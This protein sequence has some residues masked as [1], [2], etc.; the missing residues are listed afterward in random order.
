MEFL[1]L[2]KERYSCRK[3]SPKPIEPEKLAK[4]L[5]AGNIAP[6]AVNFQPQKIYILQSDEAIA[7]VNSLCKCIYGAKTVLLFAY[8][9]NH[10]WKNP[11]EEGIHSGE[12]DISIV[13]THIMLEACELGISSCWVNL[14]S[15]SKLAATFNLPESERVVLLMPLG[16]ADETSKP[17]PKWHYE[18]KELSETVTY[19]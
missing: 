7:K 2:A 8:D 4:I 9:S 19:L 6:T 14:F 15:N 3:F 17:H 1:E 12:Q 13:A 16:Y 18:K 5:E 10:D 11:T